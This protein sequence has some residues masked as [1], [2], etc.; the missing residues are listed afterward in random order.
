MSEAALKCPNCASA[1]V[2][3]S[4]RQNASEAIRMSLGNYPFRCLACNT[5]FWSSIWLLSVWKYAKCPK[6]LGL[7]LTTWLLRSSR[8]T[9]FQKLCV[10]FGAKRHR[11]SRCRCN[12]VS[13]KGRLP[14][15]KDT[16]H[17][18]VPAESVPPG[19]VNP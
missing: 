16:E 7:T 18:T 1:D 8:P 17:E 15:P 6:C 2:R 4:R 14:V 9:F 10:T 3:R 11:C 12:F 19:E 5:R 13:F